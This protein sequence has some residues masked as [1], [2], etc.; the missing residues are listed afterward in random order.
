M[1]MND[2][3]LMGDNGMVGPSSKANEMKKKR[4]DKAKP[5][6]S[7]SSGYSYGMLVNE[8]GK[9]GMGAMLYKMI[10]RGYNAGM[11][12]YTFSTK[13][14]WIGSCCAFLWAFPLAYELFNEQQKILMKINI[15][16]M[17]D[18]AQNGG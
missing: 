10:N 13:L 16:M 12:V 17:Q 9:K 6:A 18:A 3:N 2:A 14:L 7:K 11:T 8:Q 4:A 1:D 5:Q 15:N